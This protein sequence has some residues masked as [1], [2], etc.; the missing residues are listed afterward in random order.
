MDAGK[1]V[2]PESGHVKLCILRS[3]D[4]LLAHVLIHTW[5]LNTGRALPYGVVS[6]HGV[7]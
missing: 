4:E 3:D 2:N 1:P 7:P 6:I 5:M